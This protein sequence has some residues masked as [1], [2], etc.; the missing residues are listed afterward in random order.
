MVQR[1]DRLPVLPFTKNID[2][3]KDVAT[4]GKNISV[5]F[6]QGPDRVRHIMSFD[7]M[8][9]VVSQNVDN[10]DDWSTTFG[11]SSKYIVTMGIEKK[12]GVGIAR[13]DHHVVLRVTSLGAKN[14]KQSFVFPVTLR[15]FNLLSLSVTGDDAYV[16]GV[17]EETQKKQLWK[18]NLETGDG[19]MT[20]FAGV[21]DPQYHDHIQLTSNGFFVL[22]NDILKFYLG[23][24]EAL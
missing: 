23:N 20:D 15:S 21:L 24:Q 2:Y 8:S 12:L 1:E 7:S 9:S 19:S 16:F 6:H 22:E 18:V 13:G 4:D 3:V 14:K 5:L 10:V 11:M 17:N